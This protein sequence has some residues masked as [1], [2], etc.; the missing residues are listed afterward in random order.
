MR[1]RHPPLIIPYLL[2]AREAYS[3]HVGVKR[4]E[5]GRKGDKIN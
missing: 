4:Q 1:A 3:E 2:I 5:A